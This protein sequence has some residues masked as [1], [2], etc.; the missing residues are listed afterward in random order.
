[1]QVKNSGANPWTSVNNAYGYSTYLLPYTLSRRYLVAAF[2]S[3][4]MVERLLAGAFVAA[5]GLARDVP[6]MTNS[7]DTHFNSTTQPVFRGPFAPGLERRSRRPS[8]ASSRAT[9]PSSRYVVRMRGTAHLYRSGAGMS[10]VSE[11]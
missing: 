3:R 9:K 2:D 4:D 8:S 5:G 10:M 1:M 11:Q 6:V 7:G